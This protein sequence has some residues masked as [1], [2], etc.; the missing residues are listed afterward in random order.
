MT[1]GAGKYDQVCTDIIKQ[2]NADG[3][4]VI[5]IGGPLSGG[6]SVQVTEQALRWL[7][8]L[9]RNVAVQVEEDIAKIDAGVH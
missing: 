2:T 3:A 9:L 1:Q 7:P 5:I 6:L 8:T 4:V